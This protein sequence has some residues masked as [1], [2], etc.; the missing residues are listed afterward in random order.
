MSGLTFNQV[1]SDYE[2]GMSAI[3]IANKH[4]VDH[5]LVHSMLVGSG[6]VQ[7]TTH[8]EAE[9]ILLPKKEDQAPREADQV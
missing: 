8:T 3:Q 9:E 1:K 7:S 2:S 6:L 4:G 5:A